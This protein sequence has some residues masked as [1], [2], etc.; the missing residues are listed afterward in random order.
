[1]ELLFLG[2]SSMVPTKERNQ[3]GI[4][5]S[6]K[7]EAVLIDCGEGTQ[8]QLKIA[9]VPL[10]KITKILI[11]H[12]HGD[13]VLGLPGLIQSLAASD[14]SRALEIYGP[15]GTKKHFEFMFK[16]FVFDREIRLDIKEIGAGKFI[17]NGLFSVEAYQLKHGVPTLGYR[18]VEKDRRKVNMKKV[19]QLG[20]PDGPLI[21]RLQKGHKIKLKGKIIAP[22]DVS[23]VIRGRII[24]II[25]DT[26]MC[27]SLADIANGADV[28]V[29]E[30]TYSS[31]L[32][33]KGD[34]YGHLT[35]RS[36]AEV[37]NRAGAK[38]LVLTHFSARY[39][40]ALELAEDARNLFDNVICAEDLMRIRV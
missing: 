31:K 34:E 40:N 28:V 27:N 33:G 6:H 17:D 18:F 25:A 29:S 16:A 14:Y 22:D 38:K 20:I 5:L 36:A 26:V 8:R 21:G 35:A 7:T 15:A 39:K 19:E 2:T 30:A 1:M 10:T 32:K 23:T 11:T 4:L 12:W 13:H 37:A 3:S 24:G 9:G